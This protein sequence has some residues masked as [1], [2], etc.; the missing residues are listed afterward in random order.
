MKDLQHRLPELP[1]GYEWVD[2]AD[3]SVEEGDYW[4]LRKEKGI[5]GKSVIVAHV[6]KKHVSYMAEVRVKRYVKGYVSW[7]THSAYSTLQE[8]IDALYALFL[9]GSLSDPS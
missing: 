2:H 8:G 7:H 6:F 5:K 9:M 3:K 1:I 4:L